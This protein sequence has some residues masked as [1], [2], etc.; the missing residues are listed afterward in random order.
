MECSRIFA[1]R[2]S[3][4]RDKRNSNLTSGID[5]NFKELKAEF[6]ELLD[7]GDWVSFFAF[8]ALIGTATAIVGTWAFF[9]V[10]M[11]Q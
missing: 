8:I 10:M 1:K 6:G 2:V 4:A 11:Q 3:Q 7:D 9:G 5:M